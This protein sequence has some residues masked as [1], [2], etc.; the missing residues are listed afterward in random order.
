MKDTIMQLRLRAK[1]LRK[2]RAIG[3]FPGGDEMALTHPKVTR[4]L[5]N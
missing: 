2:D 5:T 3:V 1:V 4:T